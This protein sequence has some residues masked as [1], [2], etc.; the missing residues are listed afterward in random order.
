MTKFHWNQCFHIYPKL[1]KSQ[2]WLF[3]ETFDELRGNMSNHNQIF[4]VFLFWSKNKKF[5][6]KED[7]KIYQF[8]FITVIFSSFVENE[9]QSKDDRSIFHQTV[10]LCIGFDGKTFKDLFH[11]IGTRSFLLHCR[12]FQVVTK[13]IDLINKIEIY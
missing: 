3:R 8:L 5:K 7:Q 2:R 6:L 9:I 11:E 10:L 12:W 1:L 4:R 13:W